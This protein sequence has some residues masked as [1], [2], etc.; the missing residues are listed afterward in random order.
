LWGT[1]DWTYVSIQFNT[2]DS[3]TIT[4]AARLGYWSG[5]T[6]GTAWFDDVELELVNDEFV[7][8]LYLPLVLRQTQPPAYAWKTLV[9]MY[10][11]TDVTYTWEG[12]TYHLATE[13]NDDDILRAWQVITQFPKTISEW[14][15]GNG[16]IVQTIVYPDRPIQSLSDLWGGEGYWVSPSDIEPELDTYASPGTYD[17]I[18]VIWRNDEGGI[19]VPM[20]G[21]WGLSLSP[22]SWANGAG[23]SL[24]NIPHSHGSWP[25]TQPSEEVFVHEWNHQTTGF[26]GAQ[27]YPM[28]DIDRAGDYGYEPENGSWRAFL[29]DVMQGRVWDGSAYI[30]ITPS[31]WQSGTPTWPTFIGHLYRQFEP[32]R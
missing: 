32:Y 24:V 5:T 22:S 20:A 3:E 2:G 10:C 19:H 9:L 29:S 6:T 26:Y 14:S 17:S 23:Y 28:P 27:G 11:Q 7:Y 31:I 25:S 12:Q 21:A 15:G 13:M 4:V 1:N 30:G 8:T 18:I 16:H